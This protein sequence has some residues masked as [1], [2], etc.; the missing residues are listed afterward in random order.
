MIRSEPRD[1]AVALCFNNGFIDG[2]FKIGNSRVLSVQIGKLSN[3][4]LCELSCV[5]YILF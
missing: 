3:Y 5:F 1:S 2:Q 4:T